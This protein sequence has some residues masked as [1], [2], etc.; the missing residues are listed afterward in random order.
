MFETHY[1]I[2]FSFSL[3]IPTLLSA[4][5]ARLLALFLAWRCYDLGATYIED[6]NSEKEALEGVIEKEQEVSQRSGI[7]RL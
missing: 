4:S 7:T 2:L 3:L 1:L 6:L 5:A